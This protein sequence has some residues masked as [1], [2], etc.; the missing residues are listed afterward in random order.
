LTVSSLVLLGWVLNVELLKRIFPHLVAMNPTTAV[1]F[2]LLGTSLRLSRSENAGSG[3]HLIIKM[4]SGLVALIGLCKLVEVIF[5]RVIGVDQLL[6]P[7]KLSTDLTGQPNRMAPNTAW[8][9]L[10]LGGAFLLHEIKIRHNFYLAQVCIIV[11]IFDS[12]LPVIGYAYGTKMLYGIGQ[13]IPM[14]MHSA[15]IFWALGIGLLFAHSDRGLITALLDEG[16]SGVMIRRLLPAVIGFPIII[17]WLRLEGQRLELYDN[18]F[19]VALMVVAHILIFATLVWWNSLPTI[20]ERRGSA[21][22][23]R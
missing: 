13:F 17:G 5:G 16:V 20:F 23:C 10:L 6:F 4:C 8:N 21:S 19:G 3:T 18:E 11:S 22:G 14:A 2:I 12:L 1:A 9:F 15:L 7:G